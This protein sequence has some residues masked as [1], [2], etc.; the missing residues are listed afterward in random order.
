MLYL[1]S[2]P[3]KP[4]IQRAN[5]AIMTSA[6]GSSVLTYTLIAGEVDPKTINRIILF[7]IPYIFSVWFGVKLFN[8]MPGESFK[9]I[10]YGFY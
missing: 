2:L 9:L 1:I 7:T 4:Q 3:D 5:M 10:I 6:M 8:I